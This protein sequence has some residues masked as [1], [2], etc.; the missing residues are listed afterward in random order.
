M[1]KTVVL[2]LAAALTL[3]IPLR[4]GAIGWERGGNVYSSNNG[5]QFAFLED[6]SVVVYN[7]DLQQDPDYEEIY[8]GSAIY[9]PLTY[10]DE[11]SEA[12]G[13]A[14]FKQIKDNN[15]TVSYKAVRGASYIEGVELMDGKKDKIKGME[16]GAYAK[17]QLSTTYTGTGYGY[18]DVRLVLAVN[19]VG[20]QETEVELVANVKNWEQD[21][22]D[23]T[24]YSALV[25]T[26]FKVD[27]FYDGEATFDFGD[28][29]RYTAQV[30]RDAKYMLNLDRTPDYDLDLLYP[31]A[32]MEFY[33]FL[34]NLDTFASVGRL[35]IPINKSKFKGEDG[36]PR[37]YAYEILDGQLRA[38]GSGTA[39]FDSR[40]S[41]LT[42]STQ[43]LGNYVLSNQKLLQEV[44]EDND[45][46]F[47]S[48]YAEPGESAS[49]GT[50][51]SPDPPSAAPVPTLPVS[52]AAGSPTVIN[53]DNRSGYNPVTSDPARGVAGAGAL[54]ILCA[55]WSLALWRRGLRQT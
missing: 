40:N 9:V 41:K 28:K 20:Y 26:A 8:T 1:K 37:V 49:S 30:K 18:L 55:V 44:P 22:R 47:Q 23:N 51:A 7:K 24:V 16:S 35:E 48:G 31:K 38:I 32:Y 4:A 13:R 10:Y 25:P 34:G 39:A 21:I 53:A 3:G 5:V 15:V 29:I 27:S 33:N 46:T 54:G 45:Q 52:A 11:E 12:E 14:T 2:L 42:L 36:Q 19:R 17:I 6:E 50:A 43:T